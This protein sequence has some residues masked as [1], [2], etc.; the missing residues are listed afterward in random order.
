MGFKI[1]KATRAASESISQII[2]RAALINFHFKTH[3]QPARSCASERLFHV[4]RIYYL[5]TRLTA[6]TSTA[7]VFLSR[8]IE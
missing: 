8:L 4:S 3:L 5:M 7:C 6:L 2:S 1:S